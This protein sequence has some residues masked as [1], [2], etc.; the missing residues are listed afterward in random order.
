VVLVFEVLG[1][2]VVVVV[3][4]PWHGAVGDRDVGLRSSRSRFATKV[5]S[6]NTESARHD[7]EQD[8]TSIS[9]SL[10]FSRYLMTD[11][12]LGISLCTLLQDCL[13][14]TALGNFT[15]SLTD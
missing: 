1:V 14:T 5:E 3:N 13:F 6:S 9:T 7:T 2:V 11:V 8:L 12:E 4:L 10:S 15:G